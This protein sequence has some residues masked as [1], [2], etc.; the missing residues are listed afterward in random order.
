MK[1]EKPILKGT[2]LLEKFDGKGGWTYIQVSLPDRPKTPFGFMPIIGSI[3]NFEIKRLSIMP[4]GNGMYML[5]V[6]AEIRKQIQKKVGD[7]VLLE[8]Y[9]DRSV[10]ET[11][12]EFL[13]CLHDEPAAFQ[14]YSKLS[15]SEKK[16]YVNWI[17]DAKKEETKVNRMAR[18][19]NK[20]AAGLKMYDKE[21]H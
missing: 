19:I 3:D 20:L 16:F 15:Q 11:P 6:R 10:F 9:F 14:F 17:Y 13:I 18:A 2:F 7:Q 21:P 5:P 4:M 12:E 8:L 1:K